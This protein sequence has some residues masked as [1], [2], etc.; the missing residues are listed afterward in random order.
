MQHNFVQCDLGTQTH[1]VM[2]YDE[3]S[4]GKGADACCSMRM[5]Y[6]LRKL[7]ILRDKGLKPEE[8]VSLMILMDNCTGQNKSR[9]VIQFF[10]LLSL[11]YKRVLLFY[12]IRGHT[13]MIADRVVALWRSAI[14]Q[15]NLYSLEDII[16]KVRNVESLV[17]EIIRNTEESS[18]CL[19]GWDHVLTKHIK[20]LPSGYSKNYYFEIEDG[21]V[22][23]KYI[24]TTPNNNALSFVIYKDKVETRQQLLEELFGHSDLTK[25]EF[26][27]L[28]LSKA[29][30]LK[31]SKKKL[32]SLGRKYLTIPKKYLQSYPKLS[33]ELTKEVEKEKE[34]GLEMEKLQNEIKR[35]RGRKRRKNS[36][37]PKKRKVGRPRKIKIKV[38]DPSQRDLRF[39]FSR[40]IE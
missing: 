37:N 18:Q 34:D 28:S 4:Q 27:T 36:K 40:N 2:F 11:L 13:K 20:K 29:E 16:G 6:Q 30:R 32:K 5:L 21:I 15:F 9:V 25:L 26:S 14:R 1:S 38:E 23:F 12:F 33:D 22:N 3:R 31:L 8:E 24:A 10:G 7:K 39:F 17:P 19:A 35:K